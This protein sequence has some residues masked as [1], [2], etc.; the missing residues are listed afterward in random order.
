MKGGMH[1]PKMPWCYHVAQ[2]M[3]QE[4]Y[5]ICSNSGADLEDANVSKLTACSLQLGKQSFPEKGSKRCI[6]SHL[7][8]HYSLEQMSTPIGFV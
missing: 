2:S 6:S 8:H 3:F 4:G 5:D 1:G 7:P